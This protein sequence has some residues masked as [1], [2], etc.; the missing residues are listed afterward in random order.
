M[1]TQRQNRY[2]QRFLRRMYRF[3]SCAQW[4]LCWHHLK[5]R[6]DQRP[7][8]LWS[9]QNQL[10]SISRDLVIT[11]KSVVLNKKIV[12][13]NVRT[14]W[15]QRFL[16]WWQLKNRCDRLKYCYLFDSKPWTKHRYLCAECTNQ[17]KSR[18]EKCAA[19]GMGVS[20]DRVLRNFLIFHYSFLES[21]GCGIRLVEID[22]PTCGIVC[23]TTPSDSV[24]ETFVNLIGEVIIRF[25]GVVIQ[26]VMP[27]RMPSWFPLL[28]VTGVVLS[29]HVWTRAV[30]VSPTAI[31]L[32]STG[33][34]SR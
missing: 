3:F 20:F 1:F 21:A 8:T 16:C 13:I 5:N 31:I 12:V 15:L 34:A 2:C 17:K 23:L 33:F 29:V 32:P 6:C 28:I 4:F 24:S 19:L 14:R 25:S 30:V 22:Q 11:S 26:N 18:T 10:R 27:G 9:P 7:K